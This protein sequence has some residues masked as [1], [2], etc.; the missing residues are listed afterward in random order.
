MPAIDSIPHTASFGWQGD[1]SV[2]DW[3][4]AEGFRFEFLQAVRLLEY[5]SSADT[6]QVRQGNP[7]G[8]GSDPDLESVQLRAKVGFNFPPSEVFSIAPANA[9][10]RRPE[11]IVNFFSLAGAAA[12]LPD[13]V[14]ELLQAQLRSR[15][16]GLRDFLDIFH[17]RLLSL[18]YR[19]QMRHR[20]WLEWKSPEQSSQAG[21]VLTFAGLGLPEL[22]GRLGIP[23]NDLLP[24]AGLYWQRPRSTIA[25]EHIL[26]SSFSVRVA[27]RQMV[28]L[29]R[30]VEPDDWTRI[31]T[32]GQNQKLGQTVILGK[33]IWDSQGCFEVTLGPMT[34]PHFQSFLP[35]G[36]SF[37][38][39]RSLVRLYA[40]NLLETDVCLM[41]AAGEV[42]QTRLGFS[43]LGWTSWIGKHRNRQGAILKLRLD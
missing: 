35:P 21:Y 33:R 11:L 3:L 37:K 5:F 32:T 6:N 26:A 43:R 25:L 10:I 4:F 17:H 29:W 24:Y 15:N 42:P 40:G 22:R 31:G 9:E 16:T 19:V 30:K 2:R 36:L 28:G 1:A 41:L 23:D 7:L 38:R 13:W 27:I 14:A 18:L 34:L 20:L 39:L 12:P 8:E